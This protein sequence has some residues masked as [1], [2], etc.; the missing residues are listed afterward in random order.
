MHYH[1]IKY[2]QHSVD[3]FQEVLVY[4]IIVIGPAMQSVAGFSGE[5]TVFFFLQLITALFYSFSSYVLIICLV[6]VGIVLLKV[7]SR[8]ID[9]DSLKNIDKWRRFYWLIG[10]FIDQ[11]N[12]SFGLVLLVLFTSSFIRMINN[13]FYIIFVNYTEL[14]YL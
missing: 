10:G 11:I 6:M 3:T 14:F 8:R 1:K 4:S 9:A 2:N 12:N 13:L 7:L 5:M